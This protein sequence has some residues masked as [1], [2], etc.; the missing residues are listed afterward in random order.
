MNEANDPIQKAPKEIDLKIAHFTIFAPHI[1]GQYA[2]VKDLILAE[3][4]LGIDA[5]LID[6]GLGGKPVSRVGLVDGDITTVPVSW[7]VEEADIIIR[8]GDVS[9]EVLNK[10][11]I[12]ALHGRPENSCRLEQYEKSPVIST[13]RNIVNSN[14]YRTMF[15]FWE[16]FVHTW[17]WITGRKIHYIPAPINFD[18]YQADGEKYDFGKFKAGLNLVVTDMW[19]EDRTPFNLI[20]AAQYFQ[21]HYHKDTK[22]H[23]CGAPVKKSFIQFLSYMQKNGVVGEVRGLTKHLDKIYRA[24][25]M[26]LTPNIIATRTIREAM[27]SGVPIVAPVG[28]SYTPYTAEPRDYKS[29]AKMIN[30]CFQDGTKPEVLRNKAFQLF[31]PTKTGLAMKRLCEDVLSKP[32]WI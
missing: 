3:R 2:T 13:I 23:I 28:C 16:E 6:Y 26:L 14:K 9:K 17:T 27:A 15:T 19:R 7:A 21:E 11:M 5:Q 18:D 32:V 10:P 20:F 1:A 22:L 25:D 12:L 8:H 24:A 31:D 30:N 4:A 29:F